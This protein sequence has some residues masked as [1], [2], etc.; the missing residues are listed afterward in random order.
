M[1]CFG[2]ISLN[3]SVRLITVNVTIRPRS[4]ALYDTAARFCETDVEEGKEGN[5]F[6]QGKVRS[7]KITRRIMIM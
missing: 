2:R 1:D 5:G 4:V 7:Y 6:I 3:A